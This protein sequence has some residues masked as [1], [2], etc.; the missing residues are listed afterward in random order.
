MKLDSNSCSHVHIR[1]YKNEK[2]NSDGVYAKIC[3]QNYL[4]MT[5][6]MEIICIIKSLKLPVLVKF[7]SL[8][9]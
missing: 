2:A 1:V 3:K 8:S 5:T 7:G 9:K 4:E 6:M